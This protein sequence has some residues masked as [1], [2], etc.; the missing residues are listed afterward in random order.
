MFS[1][2]K[3]KLYIIA[4]PNGV[5]KTT[6]SMTILPEVLDC[7]EFVNAEII[8]F[9]LSPF[10]LES[11]AIKAGRTMLK[12]IDDLLS[13]EV[14]FAIETTLAT[15][16][17]TS[18]ITKA[19]QKG[20]EVVLLFFWLDNVQQ[21]INRVS[22][23]VS[24]G[25]HDIPEKVIERRYIAGVRNLF[26]IYLDICD[27]VQVY[28]NTNGTPILFFEKETKKINVFDEVKYSLIKKLK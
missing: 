17:Y 22:K 15:K 10:N 27:V 21:A 4:G 7:N 8:A 1:K 16:S 18:L 19:K 11:V 6:A 9:G 3:K 12:R 24:E 28:D 25:G 26:Q 2:K 5:G 20:Y 23:R 13:E 14:T